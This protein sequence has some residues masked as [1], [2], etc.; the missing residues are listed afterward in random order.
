MR[1]SPVATT[2]T[3]LRLVLG[4]TMI[5]AML[6]GASAAIAAANNR[7]V[8]ILVVVDDRDPDSLPA[9]SSAYREAFA[10]L[11][12]GFGQRGHQIF[13]PGTVLKPE[14]RA[15]IERYQ[16]NFEIQAYRGGIDDD[17]ADR[18]DYLA[19]LTMFAT[20]R[21]DESGALAMTV[22]I[23]AT[24]YDFVGGN[25]IGH[26]TAAGPTG[27]QSRLPMDCYRDCVA[28]TAAQSAGI[29]AA[30]LVEPL[31]AMMPANK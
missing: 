28:A 5:G 7:P 2:I 11:A 1:R 24:A 22:R 14:A 6:I 15:A 27:E 21:L 19:T 20:V 16:R 29:A 23:E 26:T 4:A 12:A 30:K 9:Q 3:T 13:E 25:F 8:G 17:Y 18:I 10:V 31:N